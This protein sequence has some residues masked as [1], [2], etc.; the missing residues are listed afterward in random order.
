MER[1]ASTTTVQR[2]ADAA[3]GSRLQA[4]E[5]RNLVAGLAVLAVVV[6][7]LVAIATNSGLGVT[8]D[9]VSY[10]SMADRVRSAGS[11]YPLTAPT[12]THYSPGW[13]MIVGA[14]ARSLDTV[15]VL[16]VGRAL[17]IA[18]AAAV[19]VLVGMA[20]RRSAAPVWW[21]LLVAAQVG[22]SI[23]LFRITVRALTEPMF[24]VTVLLTLILV[25]RYQAAPN[26]GRLVVAGLAAAMTILTRFVGVAVLVP[27][28]IAVWR[29]AP[30]GR[31]RISD[32][33][34]AAAIA[35]APTAAWFAAAPSAATSSHLTSD[36]RAG[37]GEA[38]ESFVEA[39]QS[40]VV[41]P[42]D[43]VGG[44]A[45][46][47]FLILGVVV[48]L[49][50]L[51]A[52]VVILR[53][54]AS[55]LDG[56]RSARALDRVGL[57]PWLTFLVVYLAVVSA[58]RWWIDREVIARYWVPYAVVAVVVVARAVVELGLFQHRRTAIGMGLTVAAVAATSAVGVAYYAWSKSDV[59]LELNTVAYQRSELLDAVRTSGANQVVTDDLRP[60]Q[61]HLQVLGD[62]GGSVQ[63]LGCDAFA[64][65]G[66]ADD[67]PVAVLLFGPCDSDATRELLAGEPG[68]TTLASAAHGA[69]YI[70]DP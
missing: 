46:L 57:S 63:S 67:E 12:P 20:V 53:R 10:L 9:G 28:L 2:V 13:S 15:S 38:V 62:F 40:V 31:R 23:P 17:N 8:P 29:S 48:L 64:E 39:G 11:P 19:P 65:G 5:R 49:A 59:G 42:I 41:G 58:Q 3:D 21:C 35:V 26:P 66:L 36:S 34:L 16:S 44:P 56:K 4:S 52:A 24:V 27:L 54:S 22:L 32:V 50:P 51:V 45:A 70:V 69:V 37:F 68:V 30:G 43:D 33:A 7:V 14:A 1:E 60:A 61:L 25:E 18:C 55:G 6:G 47:V